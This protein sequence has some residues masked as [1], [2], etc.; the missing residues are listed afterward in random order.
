MLYLVDISLDNFYP[1]DGQ[2]QYDDIIE[3]EIQAIYQKLASE[4]NVK[5]LEV[6]YLGSGSGQ[7]IPDREYTKISE[8]LK[9]YEIFFDLDKFDR[10]RL[11]EDYTI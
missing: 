4:L 1:Y 5:F 2:R 11:L 9:L 6:A 7:A 3:L 8:T 10:K